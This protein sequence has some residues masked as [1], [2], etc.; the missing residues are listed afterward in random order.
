MDRDLGGSEVSSDS[1]SRDARLAE[2]LADQDAPC[3]SCGYNLR[4]LRTDQCPECR[5]SLKLGVQLLEPNFGTLLG[6]LSGLY[7][8]AGAA[9]IVA[10]V[11]VFASLIWGPPPA[12]ARYALLVMPIAAACISGIPAL[13]VS[14][15]NGRRWFRTRS[16]GAKISLISAAWTQVFVWVTL[17][18]LL[19]K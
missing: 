15:L 16:R 17:F 14:R 19:V 1:A 13:L 10:I 8:V 9:L 2:F 6:F 11:Y 5:Q 4:G 3:P 7:A 18:L 12:R